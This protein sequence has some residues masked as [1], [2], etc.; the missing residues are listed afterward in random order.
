MKNLTFAVSR[1][2]LTLALAL[3][4]SEID[5]GKAAQASTFLI[6][7][8]VGYGVEDCLV[9]GANVVALLRMRGARHTAAALH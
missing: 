4:A 7:S 6:S 5:P 3:P 9:K 8:T 1:L 2:T